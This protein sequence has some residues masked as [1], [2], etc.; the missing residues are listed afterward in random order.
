[1]ICKNCGKE[2]ENNAF[3]CVECG[4][5]LKEFKMEAPKVAP[6]PQPMPAPEEQK[7][8]NSYMP[9]QPIIDSGSVGWLFFGLLLPFINIITYFCWKNLKP[10]TAKKI[11][12]GTLINIGLIALG[13][14]AA[15]AIYVILFVALAGTIGAG[16]GGM[17]AIVL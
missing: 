11:L 6:A 13:A 15:I 10:L 17:L 9:T 5:P 1:M 8:V 12:T 14:V 2:N 7:M 4:A 16:A 3:A